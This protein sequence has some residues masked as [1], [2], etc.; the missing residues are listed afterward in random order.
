VERSGRVLVL[1]DTSGSMERVVAGEQTRMDLAMEAVVGTLRYM[2]NADEFGLWTF[3]GDGR[4]VTELLALEPV[5]EGS[6]DGYLERRRQLARDALADVDLGGPS[7]VMSAI[8]AAVDEVGPSDSELVAGVVVLTD[9][10]DTEGSTTAAAV[11]ADARAAG[12][13]VSLV[14]VGEA[15]CASQAARDVT[16]GTGG[17]CEDADLRNLDGALRRAVEALWRGPSDGD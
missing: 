7:P 12:V 16:A 4:T 13:R 9:G 10:E 15:T 6:P 8:R 5:P 1:L 17:T 14:S 3:P 2:T 11:V